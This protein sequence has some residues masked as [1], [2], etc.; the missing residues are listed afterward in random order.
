MS[1]PAFEHSF[2]K[3]PL[4]GAAALVVIC[5]AMVGISRLTGVG[6]TRMVPAEP[7]VSRDFR[8]EDRAD[9]SVAVMDPVTG[10]VAAN[11]EPG[12]NGFVRGVMRSF[13]RE[14]RAA[15]VSD[16]PPFRLARLS[17]GRLMIEDQATH[18]RV[19]LD[20]FGSTN[21][22]AFHWLLNVKQN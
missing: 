3:A 4:F 14:R 2:P 7:T 5:I 20:A 9:G 6:V 19:E 8:F 17:D 16:M 1:T 18:R 10:K 21:V 22:A 11:L 12:T 15:G 13:A